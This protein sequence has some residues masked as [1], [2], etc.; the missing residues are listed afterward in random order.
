MC[1]CV[2]VCVCVLYTSAH[3][4]TQPYHSP[5]H[6]PNHTLTH[7]YTFF[8]HAPQSTPTYANLPSNHLPSTQPFMDDATFN[9]YFLPYELAWIIPSILL[10]VGI[11]G[12]AGFVYTVLNKK[13]KKA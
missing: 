3:H 12:V 13:K 11:T 6:P 5:T 2:C 1:V 9:S 8:P 7:T 10:V 4:T